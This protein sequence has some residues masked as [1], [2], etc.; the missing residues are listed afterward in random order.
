MSQDL[1]CTPPE[2][3]EIANSSIETL[4]PTKSRKLYDF[5]YEKFLKWCNEYNVQQYT[6]NVMLAYFTNLSRK[7]KSSTLWAQYSMIKSQLNIKHNV[8]IEKYSKLIAFIKRQGE[9]YTPKKS[10]VLTQDQFDK[11]LK[12]APNNVYLATK[13]GTFLFLFNHYYVY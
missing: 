12:D 6:E 10:K 3:V 7:F 9:N 4:I 5:A 11:F 8:K 2:L 1:Q 13:V